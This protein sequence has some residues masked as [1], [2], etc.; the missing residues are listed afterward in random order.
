M[1]IN[2]VLHRIFNNLCIIYI[3]NILIYINSRKTANIHIKDFY[4]L[5]KGEFIGNINKYKF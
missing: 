5:I 1:L 4:S 2:N 3:N